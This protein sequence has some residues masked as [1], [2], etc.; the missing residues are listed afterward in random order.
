MNLLIFEDRGYV[1]LQPLT[2]TRPVYELKC[3]AFTI[4]DRIHKALPKARLALACRS[5]LSQVSAKHKPQA[6]VNQPHKLDEDTLLVNSRA[7]PLEASLSDLAVKGKV[8]VKDGELVAC[9]LNSREVEG[10]WSLIEQGRGSELR[11]ELKSSREVVEAVGVRLIN[12]LWELVDLSPKLLAL[13]LS[14]RP[15]SIEGVVEEGVV[16]KGDRTKLTIEE[17][18]EVEALSFIDLR[19]GPVFI[20]RGSRIEGGSRL[21]GPTYV[22]RNVAIKGALIDGGCHI[23]EFCRLGGGVE[24]EETIM[25]SYSNAQ[26]LGFIGHSY[27]GRWVNVAAGTIV[28]DLKNTYGT[29]KMREGGRRVDTGLIKLGVFIADYAK[30]S[31]GTKL[32]AGVKVGVG[33]HIHGFVT[34]DVPSFTM[35]ALSLGKPPVE[36]KLESVIETA[37]RMCLR[38]GVVLEMEE[39]E[40]L[41]NLLKI[42]EEE[43]LEAGVVKQE[44]KL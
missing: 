39:V 5:Y 2:Y 9:M 28:S 43:R 41:K 21:K 1:N 31:I 11:V 32:Y 35:W 38:R 16:V 29:I 34:R 40:L 25:H 44:F 33:S 17:G 19:E 26:H 15:G 22:G 14:E 24:L 3:G 23:G 30:T 12:H 4:C 8:W 13:D 10:L 37:R 36:L 7:I 42:T 18:A 6:Y 20:G 27:V